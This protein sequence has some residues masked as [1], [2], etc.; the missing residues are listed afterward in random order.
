MLVY[1]S[2]HFSS[3]GGGGI[4]SDTVLMLHGNGTDGS[5]TFTDSSLTT[6]HTPVAV[7]NAQIDT[8]QSKFGGA[9]IYFDG[10]GDALTI[11]NDG[12]FTFGSDD[13]TVDF[14]VRFEALPASGAKMTFLA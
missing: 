7:G 10:S 12:D 5:T 14:W 4:D 8:A 9:S 1:P 13:L 11:P 6:P 3:S 2:T